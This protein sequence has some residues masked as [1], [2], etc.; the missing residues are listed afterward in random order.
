MFGV[1]Q[2]VLFFCKTRFTVEV[3]QKMFRGSQAVKFVYN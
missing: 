1:G 3:L 2:F